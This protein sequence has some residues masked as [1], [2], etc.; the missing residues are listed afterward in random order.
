MLFT[1]AGLY[2]CGR[3]RGLVMGSTSANEE[4]RKVAIRRER[5]NKYGRKQRLQ[6]I[7]VGNTVCKK[8]RWQMLG[9]TK[10]YGLNGCSKSSVAVASRF[11]LVRA[12]TPCHS[13]PFRKLGREFFG[14]L[15]ILKAEANPPV[16]Y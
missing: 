1:S 3:S 2:W 9:W 8:N 13:Q 10:K 11:C 6:C 12:S 14:K 5:R 4:A 7:I 15:R 16:Q